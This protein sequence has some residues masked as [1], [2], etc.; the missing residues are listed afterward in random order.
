MYVVCKHFLPLY[1]LL[2]PF[3]YF[4]VAMQK[5]FSF[6]YYSFVIQFEIRKCDAP[7]FFVLSGTRGMC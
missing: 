7:S 5:L 2:F 1:K 4:S 3:V 6:D